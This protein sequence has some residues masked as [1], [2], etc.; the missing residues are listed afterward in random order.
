MVDKIL[1]MMVN[2]LNKDDLYAGA[3]IVLIEL[4]IPTDL[5][6]YRCLEIAAVMRYTDPG[7]SLLKELYPEVGRNC[8]PRLSK[9]Q[10]EKNIR[11]AIDIAWEKRDV[12][13]WDRYFP[14][15]KKP[16]NGQFISEVA[17]ILRLWQA[18]CEE[19]AV[20]DEKELKMK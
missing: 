16:T 9:D 11:Y 8:I 5:T 1:T 10:V 12:Q 7:L 13:T 17:E 4:S 3:K 15:G 14:G 20:D 19:S 18:C 2:H 6:G